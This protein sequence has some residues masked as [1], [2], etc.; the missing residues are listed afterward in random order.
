MA[1][2]STGNSSSDNLEHG[3]HSGTDRR[4]GV[5]NHD[6][7]AK[8]TFRLRVDCKKCR[9]SGCYGTCFLLSDVQPEQ[10]GY[11]YFVTA[12]HL[13]YC[14]LCPEVQERWV[15]VITESH[16]SDELTKHKYLTPKGT[17]HWRKAPDSWWQQSESMNR[18]SYDYGIFA[19]H[20]Q[21]NQLPSTSQQ[22][23]AIGMGTAF[24]TQGSSFLIGYPDEVA[25][26]PT[27]GKA[28]TVPTGLDIQPLENTEDTETSSRLVKHNI[29]A[30]HGQSGSP[31]YAMDGGSL[32]GII[33]IHVGLSPDNKDDSAGP[34]EKNWNLAVKLYGESPPLKEL[35]DWA[36]EHDESLDQQL[37][38][39]TAWE[40]E[41]FT[42][43]R[44]DLVSTLTPGD[45]R[46][47]CEAKRLI[48]RAQR[49][50]FALHTGR[51][52]QNEELLDALSTGDDESFHTFLKC[53]RKVEPEAS[54]RR[55]L[56]KLEPVDKFQQPGST[57]EAALA[58]AG[59][60]TADPVGVP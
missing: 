11:V 28:F 46:R 40:S 22:P 48:T 41:V 49:Q 56:A 20:L 52:V 32:I 58:S 14:R 36:K 43:L 55:L 4:E 25:H 60:S 39:M 57:A 26:S 21:A 18:F 31:V 19:V 59:A 50:L 51:A 17:D 6:Q 2:N 53:I 44:P 42:E 33:G 37:S 23:K 47:Q 8:S 45:M 7:V 3:C 35:K 29:D 13:M 30:S 54:A 12:A 27:R 10:G 9:R 5:R 38:D 34:E 15:R 1:E 24:P 16:E